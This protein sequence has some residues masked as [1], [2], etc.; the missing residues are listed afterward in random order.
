MERRKKRRKEE[1]KVKRIDGWNKLDSLVDGR[2]VMKKKVI[3][4]YMTNQE[5]LRNYKEEQ[6]C[7][8]K[9]KLFFLFS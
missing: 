7:A 8:R 5:T 1:R 9:S 6:R 2:K 4:T 3:K